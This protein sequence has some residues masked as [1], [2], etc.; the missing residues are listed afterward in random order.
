MRRNKKECNPEDNATNSGLKCIFKLWYFTFTS[1]IFLAPFGDSQVTQYTCTPTENCN[2]RKDT[3]VMACFLLISRSRSPDL[4]FQFH[5]F[6]SNQFNNH[7]AI[8]IRP[9]IDTLSYML[10]I[11]QHF[12]CVYLILG[13]LIW[14]CV[15]SASSKH[16]ILKAFAAALFVQ[17][18]EKLILKEKKNLFLSYFWLAFVLLLL[19]LYSLLLVAASLVR[20]GGG[21]GTLSELNIL[22][23]FS[24]WIFGI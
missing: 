21:S 1:L 14:I 18:E 23:R 13:A 19:L 11:N 20:V 12:S 8:G 10:W 9:T 15:I 16:F 5:L 22:V 7:P 6:A 3:A 4:K 2:T 17:G 24:D